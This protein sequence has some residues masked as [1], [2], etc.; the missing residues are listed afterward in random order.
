MLEHE[1]KVLM[2]V[3]AVPVDP[4]DPTVKK[5][6]T[7]FDRMQQFMSL[8]YEGCYHMMG[9]AGPSLGRDLYQLQGVADALINSA[10]TCLNELPDYRLRPMVVALVGGQIG[11]DNSSTNNATSSSNLP[12]DVTMDAE[13][14]SMDGV[15]HTRAAQAALLSDII[16]DLGASYCAIP[17]HLIIF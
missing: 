5:P 16:S 2:G 8:L 9:S 13:E 17:I 11:L 7:P 3:C 4:L 10:F 12:S 6:P 15:A 1:K 14:H